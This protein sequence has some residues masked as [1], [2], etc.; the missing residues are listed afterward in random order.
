LKGTSRLLKAIIAHRSGEPQLVTLDTPAVRQ[1]HILI[2]VTNMAINLSEEFLKIRNIENLV[3]EEVDG[4][5]LGGMCSGLVEK[6]SSKTSK[7]REG[8]RVAAVGQPFVYHAQLLSVPE[9]L[10]LE[11]PKRVNHEEGAFA[12]LGARAVH[13][14]RKSGCAIGDTIVVFGAGMLGILI[15]QVAKAA[16]IKVI[17]V[18]DDEFHLSKARTVG[19]QE[20]TTTDQT[21]LFEMVDRLTDGYG[22]DAALLTLEAPTRCT[23]LSSIILRQKGTLVIS[24]EMPGQLD[25]PDLVASN[26][27]VICDDKFGFGDAQDIQK[28]GK[29]GLDKPEVG[30]T[31]NRNMA[32]FLELLGERKVQIS[33]IITERSPLDRAPSLYEKIK[34]SGFAA[35]GAVLSN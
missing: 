19:V 9:E 29:P 8:L 10:C 14:V 6:V 5:P 23:Y 7:F 25:I 2:R 32:V 16:G 12:G 24:S 33:P 28:F 3:D 20:T 35:V 17:L 18:D 13:L 15:S 4:L 31:L 11:L 34:R 26:I 1:G 27:Q 22:C 30:W 21:K